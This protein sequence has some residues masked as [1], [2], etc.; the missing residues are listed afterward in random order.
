M[1]Y[2]TRRGHRRLFLPG[3]DWHPDRKDAKTHPEPEA[4]PE[5]Y[6]DLIVWYQRFG[7][8]RGGSTD[9]PILALRGLGR[10][11]WQGVDPDE[12]VSDLRKGWE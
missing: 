2:E 7:K 10:E 1:L 9:D 11:I 8:S 3:D 12:Y 6:R 4:L 5:E